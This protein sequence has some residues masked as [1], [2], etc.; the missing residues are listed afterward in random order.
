MKRIFQS[1]LGGILLSMLNLIVVAFAP[2]DGFANGT[3]TPRPK[4]IEVVSFPLQYGVRLNRRFFS[5]KVEHS[6][7]LIRVSDA[8]AGLI[9]A[10]LLFAVLTY[11]FLLLRSRRLSHLSGDDG[12]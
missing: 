10:F 11:I 6:W 3:V 2:T 8:I 5:P 12:K 1:C 9:G 7:A 4:W